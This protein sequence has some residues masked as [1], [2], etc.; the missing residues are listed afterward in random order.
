MH[1]RLVKGITKRLL[2]LTNI[3]DLSAYEITEIY[4]EGGTLKYFLDL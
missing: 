4:K 2:F 3:F 1:L